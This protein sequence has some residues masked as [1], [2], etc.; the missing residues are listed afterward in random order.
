VLAQQLPYGNAALR[1]PKDADDLL[2]LAAFAF[3]SAHIV[4][5]S[6]LPAEDSQSKWLCLRGA[7]QV[8]DEV[9]FVLSHFEANLSLDD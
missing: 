3:S 6:C 7:G 9:V 8:G 5:L 1:F 2:F 4:F